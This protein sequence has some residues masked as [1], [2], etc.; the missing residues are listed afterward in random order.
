MQNKRALF[1]IFVTILLDLVGFGMILPILP[2]YAESFGA[3]P[4]QIGLMSASFSLMQFIFAP[5]WGRLSDRIGRRPIILMSLFFSS[6]SLIFFGSATSLFM[7]FLARI[8]AGIFMANFSAAQAYIADVT[9]PEDRAKGMGMVGAA[10]GLG[11]IFGP[12]IGGVLSSVSVLSKLETLWH[13]LTTFDITGVLTTNPFSVPAYFAAS[14]ALLNTIGAFFYL[15]ESRTAEGIAVAKAEQSKNHS[16]FELIKA[17]LFH[18]IIGIFVTLFFLITL[19]FANL[20]STFALFTERVH[21]YTAEDNGYLFA[22]IGV[23]IAIVQGGLIGPLTHKFGEQRVL[24]VGLF[25]QGFGFFFLPYTSNL[26][27]L[28]LVTGIISTGNGLTNPTLQSLISRNTDS[29]K[30]G[31]VLGVSQS[32]GSL[33][34]VFGPAW[35][36]FF[37][38]TL[39]VP[40]PYWSGG[41]MLL[42]C[43]ILALWVVNKRLKNN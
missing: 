30:Q 29:N 10:F 43:G 32:L 2:F 7:L 28:L 15:P 23:L 1:I 12:T 24:I 42:G 38:D 36:G 33:A 35:G 19:A 13:S 11:F 22:Y 3:S 26:I 9:T 16:R 25:T 14:L 27:G 18:P 21:G 6:L 8:F 20:E 31:G 40:A 4:T 39:G 34:R 37:F 5:M 41:I 17:S